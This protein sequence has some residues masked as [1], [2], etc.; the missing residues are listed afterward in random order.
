MNIIYPACSHTHVII[1]LS[2]SSRRII[3][4][5]GYYFIK[6][7]SSLIC[8]KG[9]VNSPIN[10]V[11]PNCCSLNHNILE[12]NLYVYTQLPACLIQTS[13]TFMYCTFFISKR[14]EFALVLCIPGLLTYGGLVIYF[15]HYIRK[16]KTQ[17][18]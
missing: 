3:K 8:N 14:P 15:T 1:N 9:R 16:L 12:Q 2:I 18:G 11:T 4:W 17:F 6:S 7:C 10:K 13:Y 5:S